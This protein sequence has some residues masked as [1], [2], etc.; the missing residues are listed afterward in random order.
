[1][2]LL[3]SNVAQSEIYL[4]KILFLIHAQRKNIPLCT[5]SF[6]VFRFRVIQ[7]VPDILKLSP[8]IQQNSIG[9]MNDTKYKL[10]VKNYVELVSYCIE[11]MESFEKSEEFARYMESKFGKSKIKAVK[12]I[13][14]SIIK[15]QYYK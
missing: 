10:L 4:K 12:S 13:R 2:L 3:A 8:G 9:N 14:V 5:F 1:M 7:E 6:N 11:C 15:L